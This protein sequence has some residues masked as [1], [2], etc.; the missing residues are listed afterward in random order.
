MSDNQNDRDAQY[1]IE[2]HLITV[3]VFG[4]FA[5]KSRETWDMTLPEI[6]VMIL[7]ENRKRKNLL[8]WLKLAEFGDLRSPKGS[9]RHDAN[10]KWISGVEVDHDSGRPIEEAIA[11]LTAAGIRA[12]VYTSPSHQIM[13][14]DGIMVDKW[15]VLAPTGNVYAPGVLAGNYSGV[16]AEA[17]VVVGAGA[18]LLVGG[19]NR[20]YT[21][22]PLSVQAQTGLNAAAGVTSFQLRG[23]K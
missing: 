2:N 16:S 4:N 5:A 19:S 20:T 12:L 14:N 9:L 6:G 3:T 13:G 11:Q 15:R 22:Q 18:N 23:T 21:L 8:P 1:R 17:T 7:Q 10:V